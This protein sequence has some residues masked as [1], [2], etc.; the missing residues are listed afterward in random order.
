MLSWHCLYLKQV[1]L[2]P[3]PLSQWQTPNEAALTSGCSTIAPP[4]THTHTCTDTDTRTKSKA[5]PDL[6][7]I[8]KHTQCTCNAH[9]DTHTH[10]AW[11]WLWYMYICKTGRPI[12]RRPGPNH[13]SAL[14]R[15]TTSQPLSPAT[16]VTEE[17]TWPWRIH[18][19]LHP[20]LPLLHLPAPSHS[21][22]SPHSTTAACMHA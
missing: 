5:L 20:S 15:E 14:S 12:L 13:S 3:P 7:C 10:T 4:H 1:T 16:E 22:T 19:S 6:I 18:P 9:T 2:T 17:N 21:P 8:F 11:Q